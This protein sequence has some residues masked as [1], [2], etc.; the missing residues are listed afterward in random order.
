MA[1]RARVRQR[2]F[3]TNELTPVIV[4]MAII[5]AVALGELLAAGRRRAAHPGDAHPGDAAPPTSAEQTGAV[6]GG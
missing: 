2:A 3:T 4:I 1:N 6:R 5:A